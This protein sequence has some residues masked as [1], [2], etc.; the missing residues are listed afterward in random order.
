[1][2]QQLSFSDSEFTQKRRQ[3]RKEIFLA[4]MDELIS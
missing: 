1:M 4:H 2:G 3:R